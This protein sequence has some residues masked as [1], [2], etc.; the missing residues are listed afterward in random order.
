MQP[1][2]SRDNE[3]VDLTTDNEFHTL[4]SDSLFK[5]QE[6]QRCLEDLHLKHDAMWN[7]LHAQFG[8]Q[9]KEASANYTNIEGKLYFY[10]A[11]CEL[12]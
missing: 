10:E 3:F 11:H 8:A 9:S 1:L 12:L 6:H 4:E 7:T 2:D 5:R